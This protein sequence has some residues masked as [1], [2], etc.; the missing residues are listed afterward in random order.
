L[1]AKFDS[2]ELGGGISNFGD[3]HSGAN[4]RG[5]AAAGGIATGAAVGAAL[6]DLVG[7]TA[8]SGVG[9]AISMDISASAF[10]GADFSVTA[11]SAGFRALAWR[12]SIFACMLAMTRESE[13]PAVAVK[14][15]G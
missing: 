1:A 9:H 10:F 4:S 7:G 14:A 5:A 11:V 6:T 8:N 15:P 3:A 2:R 13:A 12:A